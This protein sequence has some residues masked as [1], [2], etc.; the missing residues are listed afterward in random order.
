MRPMV[1]CF[2]IAFALGV[3]TAYAQGWLP[4]GVGSLANSSGTWVLIAVAL[5]MLASDPEA[6][7]RSGALALLSL[8]AGYV[9]GADFKGYTSGGALIA[10]WGL[11]GLIAGPPLGLAAHAIRR[12]PPMPAA[13]GA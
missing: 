10:F 8:L 5:S 7:A 6:A 12:G 4:D 11:A 3:L 2:A 13:L 1:R 9:V